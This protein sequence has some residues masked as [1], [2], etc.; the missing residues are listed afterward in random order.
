MKAIIDLQEDWEKCSQ[1]KKTSIY[2]NCFVL[3]TKWKIHSLDYPLLQTAW[4]NNYN[5]IG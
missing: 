1:V 3:T 4:K 5:Q 2:D